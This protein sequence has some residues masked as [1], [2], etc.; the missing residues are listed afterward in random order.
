MTQILHPTERQFQDAVIELARALGYLVHHVRP[1]L[2]RRGRW[3]TPLQ[4]HP[5]F[6]DLVLARPGRLILAELKSERGHLS[7]WQDEWLAVLTTCPG[8][9][10]YVWYPRDWHD[11]TIEHILRGEP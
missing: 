4:G 9:E 2:N 7:P 6:P 1:A 8:I 5:G 3:S 10:V 11:G